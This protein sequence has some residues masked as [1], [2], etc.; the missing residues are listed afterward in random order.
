MTTN[1]WFYEKNYPMVN[2]NTIYF[3][4]INSVKILT[5]AQFLVQFY[6]MILHIELKKFHL[7][8]IHN[9]S[10]T[11][12][13]SNFGTT[14]LQ[15][16]LSSAMKSEAY[17]HMLWTATRKIQLEL[18]HLIHLLAGK[19]QELNICATKTVVVMDWD[20]STFM[21]DIVSYIYNVACTEILSDESS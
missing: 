2:S 9:I 16:K 14:V 5:V 21:L 4:L 11:P 20:E 12:T 3:Y 17:P 8:P 10:G 15:V 19:I 18:R 6:S 1:V 7:N 13:I